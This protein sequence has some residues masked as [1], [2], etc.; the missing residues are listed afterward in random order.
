MLPNYGRMLAHVKTPVNRFIYQHLDISSED[1]TIGLELNL[2]IPLRCPATKGTEIWIFPP[3][4]SMIISGKLLIKKRKTQIMASTFE[5]VHGDP[6]QRTFMLF[7]VAAREVDKYSDRHFF[8]SLGLSTVKFVVLKALSVSGGTLNHSDLATWTGTRLH[9]ITTLV[10]RMKGEGLVT[11]ETSI[12]DRR[13]KKVKLTDKGRDTFTQASAV[14]RE[15]ISE[16]MSGIDKPDVANLEKILIALRK[17]A[18]QI[19]D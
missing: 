16:I 8:L 4:C 13:F 12:K 18:R 5:I 11:T 19:K 15:I 3:K 6:V 9:N 7:I 14:A 10:R 1:S 17:N 2:N